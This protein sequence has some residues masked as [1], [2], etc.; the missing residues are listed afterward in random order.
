MKYVQKSAESVQVAVTDSFYERFMRAKSL[1]AEAKKLEDSQNET[2]QNEAVALLSLDTAQKEYE[3]CINK[4][5]ALEKEA[6]EQPLLQ[7]TKVEYGKYFQ[8]GKFTKAFKRRNNVA[9]G[10]SGA[11]ILL[12]IAGISVIATLLATGGLAL[13]PIVAIAV[14]APVVASVALLKIRT[15]FKRKKKYRDLESRIQEEEYADKIEKLQSKII[16]QQQPKFDRRREARK[17]AESVSFALQ[18]VKQQERKELYEGKVTSVDD[19]DIAYPDP[20]IQSYSSEEESIESVEYES[21]DPEIEFSPSD[22]ESEETVEYKMPISN[23]PSEVEPLIVEDNNNIALS[24]D[25]SNN[26]MEEVPLYETNVEEE[27]NENVTTAPVCD[28]DSVETTQSTKN[29]K[30]L[31]LLGRAEE[32]SVRPRYYGASSINEIRERRIQRVKNRQKDFTEL[33]AKMIRIS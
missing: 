16:Q 19:S 13:I 24:S 23:N 27:T 25:N 28:N 9:L 4:V 12:S 6:E 2:S 3:S 20:N 1:Y 7:R 32:F 11:A 26:N 31:N 21:L 14:V 17:K 18:P 5:T 30:P 15:L 33:K 29:R 10:R 22:D 8:D